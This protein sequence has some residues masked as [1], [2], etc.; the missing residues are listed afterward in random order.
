MK[1][2]FI[3]L[4]IIL[5]ILTVTHARADVFPKSKFVPPEGKVLVFVGQDKDTLDRYHKAVGITPAGVMVY[6]SI[7]KKIGRAHV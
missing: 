5:F 7:Q 3:S 1:Q 2:D 6:T 4:T